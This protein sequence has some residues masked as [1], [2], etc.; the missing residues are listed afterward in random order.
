MVDPPTVNSSPSSR[1]TARRLRSTVVHAIRD[2]FAQQDFLEVDTPLLVAAP[3]SE[4]SLDPLQVKGPTGSMGWL[5]SSPEH[6]MKRLL[7]DGESRI[8]QICRCFRGG[9]HSP[10]HRE[11]FTMVEWYRR[12][13]D[14]QQIAT[15][16]EQLVA[17]V[18][19]TCSGHLTVQDRQGMSIDLSPP[20]PQWTIADAMAEFAGIHLPAPDDATGLR[21][22]AVAA[23]MSS[24]GPEDDWETA[25]YKILIE[26]VEPSLA[27]T[28]RGVHLL[29]WPA[30]MAALSRLRKSNPSVAERVESYAGGLELSNGFSE[31]TDPREQRR[32]FHI[33]R[34]RRQNR[35]GSTLPVDESFLRGL[36]M[37]M[38]DAAGVA[39]GLDRLML[40]VSPYNDLRYLA[41]HVMENRGTE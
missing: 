35:D 11:E 6:H 15:D 32:R 21:S 18:A 16:V 28:G 26:R 30:P 33:E 12:D 36:A 23:G 13:A 39:L 24:I 22:A 34:L 20:W 41:P 4:A 9:E 2:F 10:H 25:F 5:I 3:G 27:R 31:L 19:S 14:Y 29:D 1:A 8:Y 40:L 17:H 37:G 38:P 7:C